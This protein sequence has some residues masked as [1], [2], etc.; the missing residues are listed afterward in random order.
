MLR[1]IDN[2][3]E[4]TYSKE[5]K[6]SHAAFL[7]S[8]KKLLSV[9]YNDYNRHFLQ[10]ERISSLHAEMDCLNKFFKYTTKIKK[11]KYKMVIINIDHNLNFKNSSPCHH[12]LNEIIKKGIKYI[13]FSTTDNGIIRRKTQE[14]DFHLSDSQVNIQKQKYSNKKILNKH[15]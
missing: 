15:K 7:F 13:F 11:N 3:I 9:G 10:G 1:L 12:C 8:G 6:Q 5:K 2:Y 14:I 4:K